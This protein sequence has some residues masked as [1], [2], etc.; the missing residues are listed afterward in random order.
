MSL[1]IPKFMKHHLVGTIALAASIVT[2]ASTSTSGFSEGL[3][4]SH[5]RVRGAASLQAKVT[6]DMLRIG[7]IIGTAV[8]VSD[9]EED[10]TLVIYIDKD[11]RSAK[12]LVKALPSQIQGFTVRV[13]E[14]ERFRAYAGNAGAAA[15][16]SHTAGQALPIQ[17]GTSGGWRTDLANGY[18]CGGTLGA[19]VQVN[20]VQYILSNYHVFESD[21]VAGGNG[22]ISTTGDAVIQPG[23]ID[24]G[25]VAS[26]AQSVASLRTL[27]SLPGANVDCSVAEVIPG[28]VRTDGS[29]LEVGG[30]S[31]STAAPALR[32]AVKKSGRT[33]GLTRGSITG[34]NATVSITYENECAGG[35]AFTKTFT[36]QIVI[37]NR[38][39]AFLNSGDSGSLLVEDISTRPRA[40]GLLYAG[41]STSAIANPIGDVL[42]FIGPKLGGTATMVGN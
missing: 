5:H 24:V 2:F 40:V 26:S 15:T 14:T 7:G 25:C 1:S 9:G 3:D 18:C 6:P 42:Q 13:E 22:L 8:G 34:L 21:I 17:L 36:G 41:S 38:R 12:E 31:S 30:L 29:I 32:K 11:H 10:A 39:N 33:T 4:G 35:T 16:I 28:M 27:R 37:G 20:G 19:L 23:L